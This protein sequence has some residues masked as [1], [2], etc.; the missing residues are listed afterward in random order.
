MQLD[1]AFWQTIHGVRLE[2]QLAINF[3]CGA[4]KRDSTTIATFGP[5]V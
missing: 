3:S 2:T 4:A 1:G 5:R